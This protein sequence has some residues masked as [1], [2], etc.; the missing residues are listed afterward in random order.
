MFGASA[1]VNS[2][3]LIGVFGGTFD[4]IHFGHLRLA[5]EVAEALSLEQVRF[6]PAGIPP[7]RDTPRTASR[8][9]LAMVRLAIEGHSRFAADDREIRR[10]GVSYTVETLE[11]LRRDFGKNTALCLLL[12][13]DAFARLPGWHRW[14]DL[15]E[16]AHL[17]IAGR[18]GHGLTPAGGGLR[19]ELLAEWRA[20]A[21]ASAEQLRESDHG[22]IHPAPTT[23]LDISAS[24]IRRRVAAGREVRHLL[25]GA[26]LDYIQTNRIYTGG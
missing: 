11:S 19:G 7:L 9:R 8:H 13:A 16:L 23:L 25:P 3:R 12:G 10:A 14:R 15:F 4:P 26:V 22:L 21:A 2:F 1:L 6:I 20:R 17:V 5:E 24:D 18:P